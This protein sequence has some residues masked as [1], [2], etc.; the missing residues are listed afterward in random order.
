MGITFKYT[1][2][3]FGPEVYFPIMNGRIKFTPDITE[4]IID[5]SSFDIPASI[6]FKIDTLPVAAY[7]IFDKYKN[8][9]KYYRRL[10]NLI[11]N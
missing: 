6:S 5:M 11:I 2:I 4:S 3:G 1:L 9:N 10:L 7:P 8:Y